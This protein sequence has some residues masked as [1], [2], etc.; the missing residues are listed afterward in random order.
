MSITLQQSADKAIANEVRQFTENVRMDIIEGLSHIGEQAVNMARS[1]ATQNPQGSGTPYTVQTGNLV[2]SVGYCITADGRIVQM[3]DFQA[4]GGQKGDG[5]EGSLTGKQLAMQ[6]AAEFPQGYALILVAGMHYAS[7]VQEIHHR[8]VLASGTLL[9]EKL[10]KQ[11]QVD[12]SK[13]L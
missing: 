12:I 7:Y 3:S 13:G 4:S 2:S 1:M 11:L 10:V 8:D 5:S 6:L 9:A